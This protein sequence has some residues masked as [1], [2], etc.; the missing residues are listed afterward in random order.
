[1]D[2]RIVQEIDRRLDDP[3]AEMGGLK[4]QPLCRGIVSSEHLFEKT[5]VFLRA[6]FGEKAEPPPVNAEYGLAGSAEK[7]GRPEK[8]PVPANND[9]KVRII[10]E[11]LLVHGQA[12]AFLSAN[13]VIPGKKDADARLF[14]II[15]EVA[16]MHRATVVV[17]PEVD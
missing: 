6:E 4:Y 5:G 13:D 10:D 9:D 17:W 15:N 14:E 16:E 11:L 2:D 12:I 3:V 7:P 8:G 1:M